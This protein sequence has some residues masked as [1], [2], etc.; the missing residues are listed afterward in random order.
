M[1]TS[2]ALPSYA[3]TPPAISISLIPEMADSQNRQDRR[4]HTVVGSGNE[5]YSGDG[6]PA[7]GAGLFGPQGVAVDGS[8]QI[9][10]A[11]TGNYRIRFVN[12][13]GTIST[14]AGNGHTS[15]LGDN[16]PAWA[17]SLLL[18]QGIAFDS[19]GNLYIADQNN[20][21]IRKVDAKSGTI[22]TVAG[23]DLGSYSGDN[24]PATSAGFGFPLGVGSILPGMSILPTPTTI[25]TA[26]G[27]G[28]SI[29]A[30]GI[31]TTVAGNGKATGSSR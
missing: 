31:V 10:I 6:G 14:I 29:L 15:Y 23:N 2:K 24:G 5:D 20:L 11:D 25:L 19:A 7:M 28:K 1:P 21:R 13:G 27:F 8:G 3:L 17:G 12:A 18:P 4:D 9:F 22:T 30:T 16:G 26:V